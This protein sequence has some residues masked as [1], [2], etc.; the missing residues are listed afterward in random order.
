MKIRKISSIGIIFI[1]V[2]SLMIT[3]L[4]FAKDE[5]I[6][7]LNVSQTSVVKGSFGKLSIIER[8][9][10]GIVKKS[11]EKEN[12]LSQPGTGCCANPLIRQSNPVLYCAGSLSQV[13]CCP[14]TS[15]GY[16]STNTNSPINQADCL[17]NYYDEGLSCS[18]SI[19]FNKSDVNTKCYS[20][21]CYDVTQPPGTKCD[22]S[23]THDVCSTI[24]LNNF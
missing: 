18:E 19:T 14:E 17:Q 2:F 23:Q 1:L 4:A 5:S 8:S 7:I 6:S 12:L 10:D 24:N 3:P 21:C 15:S 16:S 13:S 22:V 9:E 20:G 11:F